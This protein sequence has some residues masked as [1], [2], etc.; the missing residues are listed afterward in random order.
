[1]TYRYTVIISHRLNR[2]LCWFRYRRAIFSEKIALVKSLRFS[3]G[4]FRSQ[5]IAEIFAEI[6]W[7]TF[8]CDDGLSARPLTPS[9]V[10]TGGCAM[11]TRVHFS[12]LQACVTSRR[13]AYIPVSGRRVSLLA[14]S[15]SLT[16][17]RTWKHKCGRR[18]LNW[19]AQVHIGQVG[20]PI[21]VR[22]QSRDAWR[23][24]LPKIA[25]KIVFAHRQSQRL[26]SRKSFWY[27]STIGR[28]VGYMMHVT[29]LQACRLF[30]KLT[31]PLERP[32]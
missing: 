22:Q 30:H 5:I 28:T 2:P 17:Q 31:S 12:V 11:H 7:P 3:F 24:V 19:F 26:S 16:F 14:P 1:M 25:H 21:T 8:R 4:I 27:I 23:V 6:L 18:E 20:Q 10:S 13:L 32:Y 9:Q 29:C 15:G